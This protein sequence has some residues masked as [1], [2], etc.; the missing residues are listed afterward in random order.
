MHQVARR[1]IIGPEAADTRRDEPGFCLGVVMLATRFPRL[2]GDIGNP[3]SFLF[4]VLYRSV[5]S[6]RVGAVV[7]D[8]GPPAT[9]ADAIVTAARELESEGADLIATSC[10]FLGGL[11][12]R[13]STVCTVPVL[14]SALV[15]V[16]WLRSLYGPAAAL[17]VLTFDSRALSPLHFGAGAD[18]PLVV[19]GL[20]EGTELFPVISQ[21]RPEMDPERATADAVAAARQLVACEPRLAAILLECTNLSPYRDH[22]VAATGLPVYDIITAI[23]M[24]A[25]AYDP[26]VAD[27]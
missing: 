8:T 5:T 24:V 22:I 25:D 21:D 6:A 20:E 3:D 26:S 19:E 1:H 14:A 10:G 2:R 13:L 7:R 17:G 15:L 11:Q 27:R 16:P 12:D 4:P 18:G 9:V 23:R